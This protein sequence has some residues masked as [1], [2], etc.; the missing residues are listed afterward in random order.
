MTAGGVGI[1]LVVD[2]VCDV[3]SS[4]TKNHDY[5]CY[6][7]PFQAKIIKE[8]EA[9][10][11]LKHPKKPA[12]PGKVSTFPQREINGRQWEHESEHLLLAPASY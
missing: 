1:A 4:H 12:Y 7:C 10:V 8:Y 9:H 6:Y 5:S 3:T 2:L 11:V